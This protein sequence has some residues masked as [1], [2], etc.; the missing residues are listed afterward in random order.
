MN[1]HE[2]IEKLNGRDR[3]KLANNTYLEKRAEG[4]IAVKLHATDILTYL[5][6]GWTIY[7]SGGWLTHTTKDRMNTYGPARISQKDRAW[8]VNGKYVYVD[9]LKVDATGIPIHGRE[10]TAKDTI[11]INK[12]KK[13]VKDYVAGYMQ[14][15]I[16]GKVPQPSNGDCWYC[17]MK[18]EKT[19]KTWGEQAHSDHVE[20][21]I[22]E[23][24]YV[25]SLLVNAFE[26]IGASLYEKGLVGEIWRGKPLT[27]WDKEHLTKWSG[28]HLYRYL[29]TQ[30]GMAS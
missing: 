19:G 29:V 2:A 9:G 6:N 26:R 15:L 24:Y 3:R 12:T 25:P 13:Q 4:N 23:K 8:F 11:A 20:L 7:H 22:K 5:P 1:Y 18:E 28:K 16:A 27:E 21:H 17:L 10:A 14:A 30:L